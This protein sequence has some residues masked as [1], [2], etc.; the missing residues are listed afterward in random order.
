MAKPGAFEPVLSARA[1]AFLVSLSKPKQRKLISLIYRLSEH[2]GQLG[3][4]TSTDDT[5]RDVQFL[6]VGDLVVG[7]WPDYAVKELRITEIDEV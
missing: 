6:I 3:D 5:G 4:Y 2:P 1:T 7:F